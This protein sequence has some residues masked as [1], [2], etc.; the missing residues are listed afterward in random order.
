MEHR[1]DPADV[2][3]ILEAERDE[4]LEMSASAAD[5]RRPVEL[6]QQ[7]VG[8]L[9]RMDAMQ[10]Q[11][12]AQAVDVRR[13]GRLNRIEAALR[14]LEAGDYG[15]CLECGEEIPPKRLAIDPTVA[16]CVDCAG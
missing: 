9:S 14:R 6:D 11:A 15:F 3:R 8:R 1:P 5:E 4:L 10:V 12:M 2:R 16:L 13:Q 7:S